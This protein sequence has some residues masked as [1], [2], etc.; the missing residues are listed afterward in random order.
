V[1][2]SDPAWKCLPNHQVLSSLFGLTR[3][4]MPAGFTAD[5]GRQ[6]AQ[7]GARIERYTHYG[8]HSSQGD[9]P[10]TGASRQNHLTYLLLSSP[11]PISLTVLKS[12]IG[13]LKNGRRERNRLSLTADGR[14]P[15]PRIVNRMT[16]ARAATAPYIIEGGLA[17]DDRGTLTFANGFSFA[18]VKRF[19]FVSNHT[20]GFHPGRGMRTAAKPSMSWP[21]REPVSSAR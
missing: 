8:A 9:L 15:A 10:K 5:A 13:L 17:V 2:I 16:E 14:L 6:S 7:G 12:P 21:C 1:L 4:R 18:G 3:N 19:Y 20:R 11:A